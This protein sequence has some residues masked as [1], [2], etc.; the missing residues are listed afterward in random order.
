MANILELKNIH[1]SYPTPKGKLPILRGANLAI[2]ESETL[3]IIGPSGSGKST[4]L[5]VAGLLDQP[6]SGRLL[7]NGQKIHGW[8]DAQLARLRQR[9]FGFVYQHHYLMRDF[10]ALENVMMPLLIGNRPQK[11]ARDKA[12]KILEEVG[13]Q[14]RVQHRP[15]ELSGGEQQRVAIARALVTKPHILLADEPTGNLDP[16][17]AQDIQ[18]LMHALVKKQKMA[19]ILVTHNKELAQTCSKVLT[20]KDGVLA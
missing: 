5:H 4:L 2:G 6:D 7:V 19:A 13:L 11:A 12:V 16:T 1:K 10:S 3:A 8:H 20:M 18:K 17:T 14:H 15:T 9:T